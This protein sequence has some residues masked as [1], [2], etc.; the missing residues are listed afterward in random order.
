MHSQSGQKRM[1]RFSEKLNY[2]NAFFTRCAAIV[3]NWFYSYFTMT[4]WKVKTCRQDSEGIV[5]LSF[6]PS[7]TDTSIDNRITYF[8]FRFLTLNKDRFNLIMGRLK[9]NHLKWHAQLHLRSLSSQHSL[10]ELPFYSL[11]ISNLM[12]CPMHC[13]VPKETSAGGSE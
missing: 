11:D 13:L 8:R 5:V 7:T 2:L 3:K 9:H 10:Q 12:S 1:K 6:S 4:E